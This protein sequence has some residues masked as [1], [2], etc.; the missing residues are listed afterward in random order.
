MHF[1]EISKE[2][3]D[4]LLTQAIGAMERGEENIY[5]KPRGKN[6]WKQTRPLKKEDKQI[7]KFPQKKTKTVTNSNTNST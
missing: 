2:N 1:H 4:A 3:D 7:H 5:L 6:Y